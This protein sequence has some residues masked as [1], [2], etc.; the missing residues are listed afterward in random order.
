MN[1]FSKQS[2]IALKSQGRFPSQAE[3]NQ[4]VR[5]GQIDENTYD[6]LAMWGVPLPPLYDDDEYE[7]AGFFSKN[8]D[9]IKLPGEKH[10]HGNFCGP[11]TR[12]NERLELQKQ[13]KSLP[14][15]GVDKACMKHDL[16][17][18]KLRRKKKAGTP[19]DELKKLTADVDK[20]F[21]RDV[22]KAD[23]PF[24]KK[25]AIKI[26]FKGKAL[27]DN[28]LQE[29]LFVG[30][31]KGKDPSKEQYSIDELDLAGDGLTTTTGGDL[32]RLARGLKNFNIYSV[33]KLPKK[34]TAGSY[35]VNA[36]DSSGPGTHWTG[37][38]NGPKQQYTVIFDSFGMV[39]DSRI[40]A[41]AKTGKKKVIALNMQIQKLDSTACGYYVID[42]LK[43]MQSGMT[44]AKYLA[45][46]D[47]ENLEENEDKLEN[48]FSQ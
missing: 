32:E 2:L 1:Q 10:M 12:V 22:S 47:A 39:P 38:F 7:G 30:R 48:K 34:I 37:V 14:I 5:S 46:W 43:A 13:G 27:A 44:P 8:K 9:V 23:G 11:S 16:N 45:K 31:D 21:I 36:D 25:Q 33:D 18:V 20:R 28:F 6:W 40:L 42:F 35:V 29:P 3:I 26:A 41:F 15:D 24:L 4:A 17:Y 19:M